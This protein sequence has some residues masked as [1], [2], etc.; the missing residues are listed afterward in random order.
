MTE[1]LW[2]H[3]YV[4]RTKKEW[5][6]IQQTHDSDCFWGGTQGSLVTIKIIF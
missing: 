2:V 5:K 4:E 3:I 6:D 1:Y